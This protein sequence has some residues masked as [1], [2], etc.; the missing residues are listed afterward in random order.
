MRFRLTA[1]CTLTLLLAGCGVT[2]PWS[3]EAVRPGSF[4]VGP[5]LVEI[6]AYLG[7]PEP[8]PFEIAVLTVRPDLRLFLEWQDPPVASAVWGAAG[9]FVQ[10]VAPEVVG[11]GTWSSQVTFTPCEG[12]VCTPIPGAPSVG[13]EVR[14]TVKPFPLSLSP[15]PA[16]LELVDGAGT[17]ASG[18]TTFDS[19]AGPGAWTAT[20]S[21]TDANSIAACPFASLSVSP[22][23]GQTV[24]AV[25]TVAAAQ[26]YSLTQESSC[27]GQV[28]VT[29]D[30][31][32]VRQAVTVRGRYPRLSATPAQLDFS[33]V[34]RQLPLPPSQ[35]LAIV[36]ELIPTR[37]LSRVSASSSPWLKIDTV[38]PVRDAPDTL[39]V[40]VTSSDLA[41][42]TY[43]GG[44]EIQVAGTGAPVVTIPVTYT[45]ASRA[46][47]VSPPEWK[48]LVSG[49]TTPAE[50]AQPLT[51]TDSGT[52]ITWTAASSAPWLV[53][54][55][56]SGTTGAA[57]GPVLSVSPAALETLPYGPQRATV[58]FTYA[59]PG[60]A[61][62]VITVPVELG[63]WIP[64]VARV[65]PR[66]VPS[67]PGGPATVYGDGPTNIEVGGLAASPGAVGG[68]AAYVT[69]PSLPAGTY[70]VS[71]A[72]RLGLRRTQATLRVLD[73]VTRAAA[74]V[75]SPG[76]KTQ[77]A[78]DDTAGTLYAAN[79]G[80]GTVERFR[81]ASAW[82]RD[83]VAVTGLRDAALSPDGTALAAAAGAGVSVVDTATLSLAS[84]QPTGVVAEPGA[85]TFDWRIAHGVDGQALLIRADGEA[86]AYRF[87][88]VTLAGPI[89]T[90]LW[91]GQPGVAGSGGAIWIV[92][93]D[94]PAKPLALYQPDGGSLWTPGPTNFAAGHVA[95]D[96]RGTYVLLQ[97]DGSAS[98][99]SDTLLQDTRFSGSTGAVPGK[100]PP[101]IA[102]AVLTQDGLR[103]VAWDPV[104]GRV[105][106]FDLGSAPD[107]ATGLFKELGAGVV[108]AASPGGGAVMTLS[109]DDRTLFLAGDQ[110]VVVVPLP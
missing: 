104:S 37:F 82:A 49:A 90:S 74:W 85:A 7:D 40:S 73:P 23:S 64:T 20:A 84:T 10:L 44:V 48:L 77:L 26:T 97:R 107:A 78:F 91:R 3:G 81:E 71:V 99:T 66:T 2:W 70:P 32:T 16:A 93:P 1:T 63:M 38:F 12:V 35:P 31:R 25:L 86:G 46:M 57:S 4:D 79:P 95:V 98:S 42:G 30:G 96:R 43:V 41:P 19:S 54:S 88:G 28:S 56:A 62:E 105:R 58:A 36:P 9:A 24:P 45:V 76:R 59:T 102:N 13:V 94:V 51:L 80:A 33:G 47:R 75:A 72:N 89:G 11:V 6:E 67:G 53:V 21:I 65:M 22:A 39:Q 15:P 60:G 110:S 68:R 101:T 5:R 52:P 108:P 17:T 50:L 34:S 55:P 8:P 109:V 106:L 27:T 18:T 92:R 61:S 14:Y 29:M 103:S 83:T 69:L 87:D 100:L